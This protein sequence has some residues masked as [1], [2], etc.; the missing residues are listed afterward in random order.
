MIDIHTHILPGLDDGAPDLETAVQMA[1][2]AAE[3]GITQ[4]IATPHVISDVYP[5]SREQI[6]MAVGQLSQEL[7]QRQIPLEI[8]PGAE[9]R[10]EVDLASRL[11]SGEVI[12]LNDGSP[13]LLIELP[14]TVLPPD[15]ERV[16]YDLQLQGVTPIIAHPERNR[17]IMQQPQIFQA[18]TGRGIMA[19]LTASSLTGGFGKE[20][21]RASLQLLKQGSIQVIASDTHHSDG[22]RC[23]RLSAACTEITKQAGKD[24]TRCLVEENPRRIMNGLTLENLPLNKPRLAW[25]QRFALSSLKS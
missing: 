18:L 25:N 12:T 11:Q 15:Y 9:Y 24:L 10:L 2:I 3:D 5:N 6:I 16:I 21:R 22:V 1:L 13:Y 20:V 23:P 17:A 4:M 8:L 19:Q 7:K 14:A